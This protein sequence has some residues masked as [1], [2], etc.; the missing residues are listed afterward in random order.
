MNEPY[1]L[2]QRVDP[3]RKPCAPLRQQERPE[4]STDLAFHLDMRHVNDGFLLSDVTVGNRRHLL[5]AT[6]Q[7]LALLCHAKTWFAD[8]TFQVVRP[9]FVQLFSLHAFV[10][11]DGIVKQLPLAF[12]MMSGRHT[13]DYRQV[14]TELYSLT[15]TQSL[16]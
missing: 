13:K 7:Q 12:V 3:P 16:C 6:D 1:A 11:S 9:P 15:V 5:F 4:D 10:R 2:R 14:M 8:G